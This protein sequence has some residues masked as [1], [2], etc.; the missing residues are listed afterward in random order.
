MTA[1]M[2]EKPYRAA[3]TTDSGLPPTPIQVERC[4]DSV[5]G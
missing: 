1:I 4:P 3:R 2:R 5:R